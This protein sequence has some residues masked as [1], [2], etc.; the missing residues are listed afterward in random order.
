MQTATYVGA[1]SIMYNDLVSEY[2]LKKGSIE[3]NEDGEVIGAS[4]GYFHLI[5]EDIT[6]VIRRP[7]ARGISK[8]YPTTRLSSMQ[9]Q[10]RAFRLYGKNLLRERKQAGR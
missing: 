9:R 3:T 1:F 5:G 2:L 8:T 6:D 7:E 10:Q 4:V